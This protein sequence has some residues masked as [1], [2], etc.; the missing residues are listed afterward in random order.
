M[1]SA[2]NRSR[3][4]LEGSPLDGRAEL[5]EPVLED[6]RRKI[7]DRQIAD[8]DDVVEGG[9][10]GGGARRHLVREDDVKHGL[11]MHPFDRV[12]RARPPWVGSSP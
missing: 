6:P 11:G 9:G 10:R 2:P 3:D 8:V 4:V 7:L 5:D 12:G 1:R